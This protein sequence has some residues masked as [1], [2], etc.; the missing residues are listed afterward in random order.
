MSEGSRSL[1]LQISSGDLHSS[2]EMEKNVVLPETCSHP[3]Q[4]YRSNREDDGYDVGWD[5]WMTVIATW[6]LHYGRPNSDE[7]YAL[8]SSWMI[9]FCTYGCV[10]LFIN[11][12]CSKLTGV[13]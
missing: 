10:N 11:P 9:Q 8:N 2:V 7:S 3:P 1:T 6:V 4:T 13:V 5:A 12:L